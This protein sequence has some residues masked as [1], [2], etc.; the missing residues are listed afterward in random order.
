MKQKLWISF[1]LAFFASLFFSAVSPPAH[2][3]FYAPFLILALSQFSLSVCL[4]LALLCG[5]LFDL[6]STSFFALSAI[7]YLLATLSFY[8]ARKIF[9]EKPLSLSIA[10]MLFSLFF[11][12]LQFFLFLLFQ[13]QSDLFPSLLAIFFIT[14]LLNALYSLFWFVAPLK[15]IERVQKILE[16]KRNSDE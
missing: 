4:W 16:N 12:L 2:F 9:N 8:P 15:G 1:F 6:F 5:L 7:N 10:S 11:A 13:K 14:P 3:I